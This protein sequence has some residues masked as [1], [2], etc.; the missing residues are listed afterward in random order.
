MTKSE[1]I[2]KLKD[3]LS[4]VKEYDGRKEVLY[5]EEKAL[6]EADKNFD[7]KLMEFDIAHKQCFLDEKLGKKPE[8]P[9]GII[10]LA[11]PLYLAKKSKYE[12]E[13]A[14][15]R[16]MIPLAEAAYREQ[17]ESER[18]RLSDEDDKNFKVELEKREK[19]VEEAKAQYIAAKEKYEENDLVSDKLKRV[20]I[21]E[22][23][24]EYLDDKRADDL[25]E[26]VNLWY[27]EKRKD[28]EARKAEEHRRK[29]LE[30]E[31]ER[32]RAAQAAED[33]ARMQYEE[34]I[35]AAEYA[36]NASELARKTNENSQEMLDSL[37][38]M[39]INQQ[40]GINDFDN[41]I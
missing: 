15:Y 26:A 9:Q 3:L 7:S 19:R 34:A 4:S 8:K 23:L 14:N 18:K 5:K 30:L 32:V 27:D 24:I 1:T 13:I 17:Y 35:N 40:C 21:I 25:K 11:V 39:Q 16:K 2:E 29:M 31:E 10:K 36:R 41:M 12:K 37:Q 33:Y 22:K 28:D 6:K 20:E 38:Y